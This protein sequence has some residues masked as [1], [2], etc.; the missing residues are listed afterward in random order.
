M[1]ELESY[2]QQ[3][4]KTR[5]RLEL[6][7]TLNQRADIDREERNLAFIKAKIDQLC[8]QNRKAEGIL[9]SIPQP[10]IKPR[11]ETLERNVYQVNKCIYLR[12][13]IHG[14][15]LDILCNSLDD[16]KSMKQDLSKFQSLFPQVATQSAKHSRGQRISPNQFK[17]NLCGIAL[18]EMSGLFIAS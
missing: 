15:K 6:F 8:E 17:Q 2:V 3:E 13:R 1:T 12:K 14:E 11:F 10:I 5:A 9:V 4:G 18:K 7:V 16:A